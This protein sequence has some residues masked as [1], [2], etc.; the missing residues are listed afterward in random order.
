MGLKETIQQ[1]VKGGLAGLGNLQ[2]SVT[3]RAAGN[4]VYNATTGA[5]AL[6]MT[7]YTVPATFVRYRKEDIDGDAIRPEDQ[8]CLIG[9]THLTVTPTLNDTIVD[10]ATTWIVQGGQIDPAGAL[11]VIQVRRP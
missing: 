4:P 11:W 6:A 10:G 8:K 2:G 9:A 5:T 3:Y 1:A 7:D